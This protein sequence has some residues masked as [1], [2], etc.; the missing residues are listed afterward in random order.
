MI[1]PRNAKLLHEYLIYK[2]FETATT[3]D[4]YVDSISKIMS[5]YDLYL[6][7][8]KKFSKEYYQNLKKDPLVL[9]IE[10]N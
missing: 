6:S 8:C 4:E 9:E 7:E 2:S 3:D 5:N 1:I 10:K